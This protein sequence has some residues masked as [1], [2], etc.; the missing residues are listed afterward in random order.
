MTPKDKLLPDHKHAPKRTGKRLTPPEDSPDKLVTEQTKMKV[1]P[2]PSLFVEQ[3]DKPGISN[4]RFRVF[5]DKPTFRKYEDIPLISLKFSVP[6]EK[7]HDVLLPK[8]AAEA[9]RD[10]GKRG[11]D[12]IRL[13]DI[14]AQH[15]MISY[16]RR[17]E[18]RNRCVASVPDE[19][20]H[21]ARRAER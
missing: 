8:I 1:G 5:F 21:C 9:H 3:P 13:R 17:C 6:L 4:G 7:A 16:F 15:A 20:E 10:I 2:A 14:P 11:R 18:R 19:R 12:L